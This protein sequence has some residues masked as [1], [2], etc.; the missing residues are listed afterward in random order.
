[1]MK[2][3]KLISAKDI[4]TNEARTDKAS[5]NRIGCTYNIIAP[6]KGA[7]CI[8]QYL[9]DSNGDIKEGATVTSSVQ[10][11]HHIGN[12]FVLTTLNTIYTFKEV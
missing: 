8:M 2:K 10:N 1:M 11:F 12:C 5:Q 9:T 6:V 7:H 3:Y 4:N